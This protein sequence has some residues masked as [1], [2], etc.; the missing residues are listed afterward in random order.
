MNDLFMNKL[1]FIEFSD[2]MILPDERAF[3][4]HVV[5][6]AGPLTEIPA[7]T[8]LFDEINQIKVELDS[9]SSNE[10]F[11]KLKVYPSVPHVLEL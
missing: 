4:R 2:L 6:L 3:L 5:G 11:I 7:K 10:F 8:E 1:E 9:E